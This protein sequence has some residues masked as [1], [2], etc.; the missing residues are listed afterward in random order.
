MR[1]TRKD[2]TMALIA[3][4]RRSIISYSPLLAQRQ[5]R[6]KLQL[7][8]LYTLDSQI[9]ELN[10]QQHLPQPEHIHDLDR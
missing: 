4:G 3:T 6:L 5:L 7:P 2:T 9:Q 10:R 1:T 8:C